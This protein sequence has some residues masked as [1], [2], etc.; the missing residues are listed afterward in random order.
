VPEAA[1]VTLAEITL[2]QKHRH[3]PGAKNAPPMP[4][5]TKSPVAAQQIARQILFM[6]AQKV[7]LDADL[8]QL[9]G[10][11]TRRLN[12]QVRRNLER[13]PSD[14][15]FALTDQ[16]V[17]HLKSQSATSSWG[18]RRK[19]P[20][21]FTEHGAIMAASVLNSTRAIE[22]SVY[23]VR[24]FV[25]LRELLATNKELMHKIEELERRIEQKLSSH[26]QAIAGILS[27]I[28]ELM[29]SPEPNRR[30]IGFVYPDEKR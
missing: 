10:V 24:A 11:E 28:R 7:I 21:A 22:V 27:A 17:R 26:D 16:E 12:E 2:R 6:R 30:P 1:F 29:Q 8:A 14:F 19:N 20:L 18:G 4:T 15:M 9:Y 23:V 13:F 3:S 5:L 25:Q